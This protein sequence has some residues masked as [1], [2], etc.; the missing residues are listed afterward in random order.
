MRWWKVELL[1]SAL[2]LQGAQIIKDV[3][4]SRQSPPGDVLV[5]DMTD[6]TGSR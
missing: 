2:A 1:A 6:P 3:S 4:E 5:S